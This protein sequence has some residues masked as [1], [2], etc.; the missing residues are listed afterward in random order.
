[1]ADFDY[2][3]LFGQIITAGTSILNNGGFGGGNNQGGSIGQLPPI[4][5]TPPYNP[6]PPV[7]SGNGLPFTTTQMLV[8]AGILLLI[9]KK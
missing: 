5:Q 7:G 8:G 1:M 3:A 6:A 9:L 2:G 4:Y